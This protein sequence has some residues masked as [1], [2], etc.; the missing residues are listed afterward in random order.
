MKRV[1]MATLGSVISLALLAGCSQ[2]A[3]T[4]TVPAQPTATETAVPASATLQYIGHASFLLTASDGT[5]IAMDPYNNFA[6]PP[7]LGAYPE[8]IAA[9]IVT[10][11]H[12]HSDHSNVRGVTGARPIFQPAS[13]SAGIVTIAGFQGDHGLAGGVP[14]GENTVFLF[15][16]GEIKIVHM[17][18]GGVITQPEILAAVKD[19]DVVIIDAAGDEAH[20]IVEI[21]DQLRAQGARTIIPTHFSFSEKS[22]YYGAITVDE[23]VNLLAPDEVVVRE[24]GGKLPVTAG[25]PRQVVILT[26]SALSAQ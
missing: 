18:G 26:P 7:E 24:S 5:R 8:G 3:P 6:A 9:D 23:F 17:G 20:P 14:S 16:I 13:D 25:M 15:T 12:F 19:A 4:P 10:I 21:M 11:S 22:R 1:T 2:A